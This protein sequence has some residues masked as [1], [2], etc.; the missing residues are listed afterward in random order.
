MTP[1]MKTLFAAATMLSLTGGSD[2]GLRPP[3]YLPP[4]ARQILRQRM[5]R[6]GDDLQ[7]L[8]A[9]VLMLNEPLTERLAT[10]IAETPQLAKVGGSDGDL[11]N[12]S[13]P[14]RFFALQD[15]LSTQ[16]KALAKAAH[17]VDHP[18]MAKAFG[19]LTSTCVRCHSI[20]LGEPSDSLPRK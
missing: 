18:G 14:S 17:E 7:L 1:A 9:A 15:Q 4:L 8:L 20:Y 16:A 13:L 5:D 12:A 10:Q 3:A 2:A 19:E 11:L 6:H